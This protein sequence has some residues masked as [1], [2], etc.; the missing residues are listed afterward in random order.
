MKERF[1]R[2]PVHYVTGD[3]LDR[4]SAEAA[5][6]PRGRI[7]FNFHEIDDPYQR[8]L[9]V[10]Q[11]GS[12]VQPHRHLDPPKAETFMVLRG[13]MALFVFDDRGTVLDAR[14]IG[15]ER[16]T[17]LVDLRPGVWH[18]IAATR[19]DTVVFEAKNGPYDPRTDKEFASWA[20]AEGDAGAADYLKALTERLA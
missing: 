4:L 10:V 11:P 14:R 19:R 3:Q 2:G 7:N 17:L 12:Y 15:P 5:R 20:P 16:E 6:R 18:S 9:N 13:E 8:L 1:E